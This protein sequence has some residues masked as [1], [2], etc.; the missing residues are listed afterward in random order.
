KH[1]TVPRRLLVTLLA[2]ST[3][4]ATPALAGNG[5]G[6]GHAT[7]HKWDA[8]APDNWPGH[9]SDPTNPA[10]CDPID[11]AQCLLPYPNDWFT[12]P[13]PSSATGRRL[14]LNA[15]AMPRNVAG[16]PVEPQEWNRSDGFSA[17]AQILTV[18]PK[19]TK[20][21]DIALSGIPPVTSLGMNDDPTVDPG[22]I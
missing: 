10:G 11:G 20:N 19:M 1:E 14:D 22:V 9:G 15:L 7:G 13:D 12:K 2:I 5:H 16:K 4:A 17:G 21:D 8:P 18:V 6:N 3:A